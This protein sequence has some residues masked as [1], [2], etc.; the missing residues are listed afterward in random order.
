MLCWRP[1]KDKFLLY[2]FLYQAIRLVLSPLYNLRGHIIIKTAYLIIFG[3]SFKIRLVHFFISIIKCRCLHSP[4]FLFFPHFASMLLLP[5][6]TLLGLS[7]L[8]VILFKSS[9]MMQLVC[10]G[11]LH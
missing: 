6:G 11:V 1:Y 10:A 7:C 8:N 2:Y 9:F 5:H 3:S 4:F